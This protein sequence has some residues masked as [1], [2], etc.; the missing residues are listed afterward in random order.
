MACPRQ[1][2]R[3]RGSLQSTVPQR[4]TQTSGSMPREGAQDEDGL[5]IT[6]QEDCDRGGYTLQR[7]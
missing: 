4:G 1:S 3:G 6:F 5:E 7:T 2:E